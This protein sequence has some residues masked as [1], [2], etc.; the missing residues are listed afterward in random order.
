[1]SQLKYLAGYPEH[2]QARVRELIEHD[3]LGAMLADKYGERHAIRNDGQLYDYVQELKA[4]HLRKAAPLRKVAYD[5][6]MQ[7]IEQALGMHTAISRA[8]GG[9]LK[10][11]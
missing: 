5:G 2:L 8:H 9:L 6:K 10:A 1:M 11:S 7:V 4:R 3:R